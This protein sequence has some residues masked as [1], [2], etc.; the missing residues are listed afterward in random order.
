MKLA[1]FLAQEKTKE[2]LCSTLSSLSHTKKNKDNTKREKV[3]HYLIVALLW[4]IPII[5]G[6]VIV[7]SLTNNFSH[8]PMGF[9][10]FLPF[11]IFGF[12][13]SKIYQSIV[14][15]RFMK[16]L[17]PT[18][19]K[20]IFSSNAAYLAKGGFSREYLT[21]LNLF[22][23]R[24]LSVSNFVRGEYMGKSISFCDVL[25]THQQSSGK[26]SHTVTDF[27]GRVIVVP[28][29]KT[30]QVEIKVKQASNFLKG[31][32]VE[33]ESAL[34][35]KYYNVYCSDPEQAFYVLTPPLLE[36]M[37]EIA[38]GFRSCHFLFRHNELI[39]ACSDLNRK[40]M[41]VRYGNT[42]LENATAI[43]DYYLEIP[44]L[45]EE[46]HI[47]KPYL[48]EEESHDHLPD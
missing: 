48:S 7:L 5:I 35:N 4:L 47:D 32:T 42:I 34:F 11:L 40:E 45:L 2:P 31:E 30:T 20:G 15:H 46:L 41:D 27:K 44:Y 21:E 12:V 16:R 29:Y 24:T 38:Q 1:D 18:I 8:N 36:A 39:I 22:P 37:V 10:F 17:S 19:V 13:L 28:F 33:F 9:F 43:A 26:S 23:V 3:I 14:T 25:S 6:L